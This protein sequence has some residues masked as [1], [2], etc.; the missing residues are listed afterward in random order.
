MGGDALLGCVGV[1]VVGACWL[2][3]GGGAA[4][5]WGD[6]Y[7]VIVAGANFVHVLDF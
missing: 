5:A 3:L 6:N 2:G 7:Q 1:V 4:L